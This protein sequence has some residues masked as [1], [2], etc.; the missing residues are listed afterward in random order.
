MLSVTPSVNAQQAKDYFTRHMDRDYYLRDAAEF[1][2]Q[3]HGR[4]AELLG[5]SGQVDK[6]SY[7]RLCDNLD[8]R[9]GEPLTPR[10]KADRRVSYDF[11]FNAPKSVTLARELGGDD[12]IDTAF[13]DS[14]KETMEEMENKMQARVRTEGKRDENRATCNMVWAEFIHRTARPVTEDGVSAYPIPHLHCHAVALNATHTIRWS[15]AGRPASLKP[16]CGTRGIIR[17]RFT[18]ASP[19]NWRRWATASS[20]TARVSDWRAL[21]RPSATSSPVARRSSRRR[22]TSSESATR[23]SKPSSASGRGRRSPKSRWTSASCA[24]RG[25]QRIDDDQRNAIVGARAGQ[26][27]AAL[28]ANQAVDYALSH[29]F[30]RESTV[31]QKNLLKT[32]L[33]QSFGKASVEDVRNAVMERD[34]SAERSSEGSATLPH[35]TCWRKSAKSRFREGGQGHAQ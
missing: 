5:L 16:S 17:R 27:T 15:N 11:T 13:R 26:E 2:G 28:D 10:T 22:P 30:E 33:I 8:P 19:G 23:K 7:F 25:S 1:P 9:T 34:D 20:A 29:C 18:A 4:G 14:V 32:A 35:G 6:E 12:R 31:T 3:W 21:I 24:R